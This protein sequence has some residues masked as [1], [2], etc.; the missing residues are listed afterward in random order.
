MLGLKASPLRPL[1]HVLIQRLKQP[2]WTPT[3]YA[4]L[5][6]EGYARNP[7]VF[8][9]VH[10]T[11]QAA[12]SVPWELFRE[13]SSGE[14][15]KLRAHPLLK[16]WHRPNPLMG[17]GK[18]IETLAAF[19]RLDG[20]NYTFG[21]GPENGPP[22]ELWP[23]RPD[24][25]KVVPGT[26]EQRV[27]GYQLNVGAGNP[28]MLL[29]EDVL[30]MKDFN[31]LN[32]WYGQSPLEAGARST[33][34]SNEAQKWNV[35]L[36]QNSAAPSGA[37]K[38]IGDPADPMSGILEDDEFDR[39]KKE[40]LENYSGSNNAG[41]PMLLQ[42]DMD[43]LQMGL[44]PKDMDWIKGSKMSASQI[45]VVFNVPPELLGIPD[46]KTFSN[47][48]QARKALYQDNVVPLLL[49]MAGE[50]NNWL[51]PQ[52]ETPGSNLVLVPNFDAVPAMQEDKQALFERAQG[53][54]FMKV[55]E[56]R[57]MVGLDSIGPD[58]DVILVGI[59]DV[60]LS[61][62]IG[63]SSNDDKGGRRLEAKDGPLGGFSLDT[64]EQILHYWKTIDARREKLIEKTTR[65]IRKRFEVERRDIKRKLKKA[66]TIAE[67]R[68][69]V[70]ATLSL[71]TPDW[72]E[73][74]RKG[75]YLPVGDNLAADTFND[76]KCRAG[77][78]ERKVDEEEARAA[79]LVTINDY[80][81]HII[82]AKITG[83]DTV[84]RRKVEVIIVEGINSGASIPAIKQS[85]DTLYLDQFIQGRSVLIARTETIT[86]SN[87][88]ALAG[89]KSTGLPLIKIWIT[90]K[91]SRVRTHKKGDKF[92]HEQPDGQKVGED[93]VFIVGGEELL[94]PGD[95]SKGASPG[96][97]IQCRCTVGF[98]VKK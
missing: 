21:V 84:T 49:W 30:H 45:A 43:W 82:G 20:N 51:V 81:D 18:F 37:L 16:L 50:F 29:A 87:F 96:N 57:E 3:D 98:K 24:L 5:A 77:E 67:V 14:L 26:P 91:D 89:A 62:A 44:S 69:V 33:D 36:L 95:S 52:F 56:K 54:K 55:N 47:Y 28:Q 80:V 11:A 41:L 6:R 32:D 1:D 31:P 10:I 15:T 63:S 13:S 70:S 48:Q 61:S 38:I 34:Q 66:K 94:V 85:I 68:S 75:V 72:E 71:G 65:Q 27:L 92:D 4:K 12:A 2:I 78:L 59:S 46:T 79:W 93:E 97:T 74:L 60:P 40:I 7:Y 8:A 88:G 19:V 83:I 76:V 64:D 23:L 73:T 53:A 22:K 39:L 58:G 42:G 9:S 25:I 17:Q 86:A 90:T 35:R